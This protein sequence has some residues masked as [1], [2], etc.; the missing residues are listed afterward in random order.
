MPLFWIVHSHNGQ[1]RVFIQEAVHIT[2]ARIKA[3]VSGHEGEFFEA[4]ELTPKMAKRV[5]KR[6]IGR[7]LS[8]EEAKGLLEK[9]G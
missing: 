9:L 5:P 7:V 8:Q 3:N 4:L 6:M 2:Y 1:A